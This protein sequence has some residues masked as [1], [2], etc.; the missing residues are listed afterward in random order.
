MRAVAGLLY[1]FFLTLHS[2]CGVTPDAPRP[3]THPSLQPLQDE[4]RSL[5]QAGRHREALAVF[6]RGLRGAREL[7]DASSIARFLS[8]M[9]SC[10]LTSFQYRKAMRAYLEAAA[11]AAKSDDWI[12]EAAVYS[13]ISTIYAGLGA[14]P[15]ALEAAER[16]LRLGSKGK[17]PFLT[18]VRVRAASIRAMA[19]EYETSLPDLRKAIQDADS[20]N[21]IP[22]KLAALNALGLHSLRRGDLAE[23]EKAIREDLKLRLAGRGRNADIAYRNEALLRQAQGDLEG[24]SESCKA[25]IEAATRA[26]HPLVLM[27]VFYQHGEIRRSQGR[28]EE[29]LREYASAMEISRRWRLEVLP[30]DT[31]MSSSQTNLHRIYSRFAETGAE[32]YFQS[33]RPELPAQTLQALELNRAAGLRSFPAD[34]EGWER[35]LPPS[36]GEK[37]AEL[38]AAEAKLLSEDTPA[39]RRDRDRLRAE[40]VRMEAAAGLAEPLEA[41]ASQGA[42]PARL[43]ARLREDQVLLSF[44]LG[45]RASYVWAACR[46]RIYLRKLSPRAILVPRI[47]SFSEAVR[48]G[49]ATAP[50]L[51]AETF[52]DLFGGLE[53]TLR[54]HPNALLSLDDALFELPFAALVERFDGARPVYMIEQHELQIVPSAYMLVPTWPGPRQGGFLG[55]G[56]PVYN[57]ADPRWRGGRAAVPAP[58]VLSRLPGSG[59]EIREC[60]RRWSESPL[61]LEGPEAGRAAVRQAMRTRPAVL[62][63]AGHVLRGQRNQD[64]GLL[65]LSLSPNGRPELL[66]PAEIASWRVSARLVVMSGC[67]SGRDEF[68]PGAGLMG[69]THAWLAAGAK[70]VVASLWPTPDD[71]GHL[72]LSLYDH[73]RRDPLERPAAALRHAQRVMLGSGTWR[74]APK[75]WAPYFTVAR[76]GH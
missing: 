69:L 38:Q 18:G 43:R 44:H 40:L 71:E 3:K 11:L 46:H 28:L 14:V 31:V 54:L 37:L 10:Y 29:A 39:L 70:S 42:L 58:L 59:R 56:D 73:L 25:A 6:E 30:A 52:R 68:L 74:A 62:H 76:Q 27:R 53:E 15:E 50:Q 72:F 5:F 45:D 41:K 34:L 2:P 32:L 4:G 8:N 60:A 47:R 17:N 63:F 26:S 16:A 64:P 13:N 65:A 24:A 23:A 55:V 7:G 67:S 21:D 12:T 1:L 48:R 33:R 51:A 57:T 19:G 22:T 20:A 9:G 36:F 66:G 75:Y 61:L 49:A 35:R